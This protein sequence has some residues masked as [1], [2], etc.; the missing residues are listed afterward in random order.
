MSFSLA[1]RFGARLKVYPALLKLGER[2]CMKA[3]GF[4]GVS[5]AEAL[6]HFEPSNKWT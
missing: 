5:R 3:F 4:G 1:E 6:L 2:L